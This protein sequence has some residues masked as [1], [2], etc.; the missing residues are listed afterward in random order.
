MFM[1]PMPLEWIEI[2]WDGE[3]MT[4]PEDFV[5]EGEEELRVPDNYWE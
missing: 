4:L 1:R 5:W 2:H 3:K